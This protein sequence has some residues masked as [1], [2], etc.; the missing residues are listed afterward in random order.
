MPTTNKSAN[1]D[2]FIKLH[3]SVEHL[4]TG[5]GTLKQRLEEIFRSHLIHLLCKPERSEVDNLI[6]EATKLATS[7]M[8]EC[9]K[10]GKLHL[11][12]SQSHW[13]T[14]RQIAEKIFKAFN[15]ASEA[16]YK[17]RD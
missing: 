12:L 6:F 10:L 13:Q 1:T 8:D 2:F 11:T 16:F 17:D 9:G 3:S 15:L 5:K 7:R 4:V 14:D